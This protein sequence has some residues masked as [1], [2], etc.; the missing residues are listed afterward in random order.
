MASI[1]WERRNRAEQSLAEWVKTYMCDGLALNEEPSARG[2]EVLAE[3]QTALTAHKNYMI[4]M[5]R[6][7]GK[8]S[9][10]IAATL[11]AIATGQ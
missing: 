6:G 8:S 7:Q 4:C 9:F 1:D 10:C 5:A 11:Y 3:M 2:C